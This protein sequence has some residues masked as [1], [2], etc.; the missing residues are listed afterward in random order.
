MIFSGIILILQSQHSKEQLSCECDMLVLSDDTWTEVTI[1]QL[2]MDI[3]FTFM[4]YFCPL[5][6]PSTVTRVQDFNMFV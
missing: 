6:P 5:N 4:H 1:G 2:Q 3:Y